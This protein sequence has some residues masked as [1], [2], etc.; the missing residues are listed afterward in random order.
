VKH[1]ARVFTF[2]STDFRRELHLRFD[3]EDV[4]APLSRGPLQVIPSD[5]FFFFNGVEMY[6]IHSLY[7]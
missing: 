6:V 5:H 3:I 7:V 2:H 4:W 1:V